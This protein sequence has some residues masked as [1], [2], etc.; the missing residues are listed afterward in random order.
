MDRQDDILAAL[1]RIEVLLAK[2]VT[3]SSV[4]IELTG[5]LAK[6]LP[7]VDPKM[8]THDIGKAMRQIERIGARPSRSSAHR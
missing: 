2:Q 4:H 5:L 6:A 3:M 1:L 8:L 7:E